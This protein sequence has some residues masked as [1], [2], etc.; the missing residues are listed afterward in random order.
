MQASLS[1]DK[2]VIRDSGR[3]LVASVSALYFTEAEAMA[4]AAV[5]QA[6]EAAWRAEQAK[7]DAELDA[8]FE[9]GLKHSS[10]WR[11]IDEAEVDDE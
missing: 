10:A 7:R 6:K 2:W 8:L 11:E 9:F 3:H 4:L 1:G 5:L